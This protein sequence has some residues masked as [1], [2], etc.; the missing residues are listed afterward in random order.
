[1]N[2]FGVHPPENEGTN[3]HTGVTYYRYFCEGCGH[4]KVIPDK[5]DFDPNPP[6]FWGL[7]NDG[8]GCTK[9]R[10]LTEYYDICNKCQ[11]P[12]FLTPGAA[13][14]KKIEG[15]AYVQK[16]EYCDDCLDEIVAAPICR[17]LGCKSIS[18]EGK[19]SA[20]FGD[21]LFYKDKQLTFPPNNCEVCRAAIK[22]FKLQKEWRPNCQLC[23]KPFRITSGVMIMI[24]KNEEKCK[25]PKECLRC[26]GLSPDERR[27]MELEKD[28][29][30][31]SA[32]RRKEVAKILAGNKQELVR[33]KERLVAEKKIKTHALLRLLEQKHKLKK[34]DVRQVLQVALRDNTVL[35]ILADPKELGYRQVQEALAHVT[36]GKGKMTEKE[37]MALP[38][39][40]QTILQDHP[41]AMG[42]FE[43]ASKHRAPGMS[44]INQHYE[45]LS[46]AALKTTEFK[47]SKQYNT[48]KEVTS[49]SDKGLT[50]YPTDR[51]D[52]GIKFPHEHSQPKRYRTIEADIL[53][54]RDQGLLLPEKVI[55]VD[56][57]YTKSKEYEVISNKHLKDIQ[58]QLNGIRNNFNDGN[59]SEYNFVTNKEFGDK[60]KA[61]VVKTNLQLIKDYI[62]DH[63]Q[64]FSSPE[65]IKELNYLTAQEREAMPMGIVELNTL[66]NL[67]EYSKAT[68][69]FADKYHI[70]QIEL[71]E[72]VQYPGT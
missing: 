62:T 16:K 2:G 14:Y 26:R 46:A 28:L 68:A 67:Q 6:I 4:S 7:N 45:I 33:E 34:K 22:E 35:K 60:F 58:R 44:A 25:I 51:V 54:H 66:D 63:N 37:F 42:I 48:P 71:C 59:L 15:D 21:Q 29:E 41:S 39:A 20:T 19:V 23:K 8:C 13:I 30:D 57:K 38:N 65:A 52:F 18:G 9:R 12:I 3:E 49:T 70:N 17:N 10:E 53:I 47:A 61:E 40:F 64:Q 69:D 1:M 31:I 27:G 56:A 11:N 72:Y 55:G 50:I 24:L 5:Y 43:K 36:G 32:K